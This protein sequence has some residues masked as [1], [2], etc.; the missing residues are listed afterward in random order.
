MLRMQT[1]RHSTN[2]PIG[3]PRSGLALGLSGAIDADRAAAARKL[4]LDQGAL[5]PV[6]DRFDWSLD[7]D[8]LIPFARWLPLGLGHD[9]I[10]DT[11]FYLAD[12]GTGAVDVTVDETENTRLFW[13]SAQDALAMAERDEISVIFP[14]RRN[15]ER[16]AQF[17]SFD[18]ARAH[19]EAIPVRTITPETDTSGPRPVLRIPTD[20]GYPVTEEVLDS[21]MRG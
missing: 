14:T 20:A 19:A 2:W 6:L 15:L 4:A 3:S 5:A 1:R 11:R 12:L 17:S 16:L 18:E 21:A 7:L 13:T 9:R 10:F 8:A